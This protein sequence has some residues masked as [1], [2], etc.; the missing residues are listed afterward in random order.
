MR[1]QRVVCAK[2]EVKLS[3][4]STTTIPIRLRGKG[5]L[6]RE[7]D[8]L[9]SPAKLSARLGPGGGIVAHLV[10]AETAFIKAQNTIDTIVTIVKDYHLGKIIEIEAD[11]YFLA[12]PKDWDLAT[13][14]VS[15]SLAT[16]P[17][18]LNFPE[19]R[20]V[21]ESILNN[22]IIV[23][24]DDDTRKQLAEVALAYPELWKDSTETVNIPKDQYLTIPLKP[25]SRIEA[26]KVYLLGPKD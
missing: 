26:V 23:Y 16:K 19:D 17:L 20:Q 12:T 22:E 1:V 24:G 18:D 7:R 5:T 13:G 14:P 21:S 2:D 4:S 11:S 6:P 15:T 3:P 9:F 8:F 10:N 25:D